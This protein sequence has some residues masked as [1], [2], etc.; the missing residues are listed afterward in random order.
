MCI[1]YTVLVWMLLVWPK[2]R[3]RRRKDVLKAP[4]PACKRN[5][6]ECV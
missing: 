2:R 5:G 6:V 4:S 3:N 1:T